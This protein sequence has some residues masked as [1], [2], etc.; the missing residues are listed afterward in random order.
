MARLGGIDSACKI[1]LATTR[2]IHWRLH[3]TIGSMDVSELS[4][5]MFDFSALREQ[6][7]ANLPKIDSDL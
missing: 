3:I 4:K 5:N 1:A 7:S 2:I 6:S